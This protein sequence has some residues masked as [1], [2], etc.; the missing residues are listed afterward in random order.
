MSLCALRQL[1]KDRTIITN[2]PTLDDPLEDIK[3]IVLKL[4]PTLYIPKCSTSP[5]PAEAEEHIMAMDH[6]LNLL[7]KCLILDP[8]KRITAANALEHPFFDQAVID[9]A[10]RDEDGEMNWGEIER[11]D[12]E[13]QRVSREMS[14][15]KPDTCEHLHRVTS[16]KG[17]D[18]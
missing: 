3:S 11:E 6:A 18:N 1:T 10:Q 4:N 16:G 17:V 12:D 2:V 7:R 15:V 14:P 9:Q 8:T 13:W 5:T